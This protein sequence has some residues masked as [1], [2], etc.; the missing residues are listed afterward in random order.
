MSLI[1]GSLLSEIIRY[2]IENPEISN[3]DYQE[4]A[5][6]LDRYIETLDYNDS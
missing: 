2:L 5:E 6:E 4:L 1:R 3:R